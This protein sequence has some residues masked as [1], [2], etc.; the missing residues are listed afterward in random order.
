MDELENDCKY[1]HQHSSTDSNGSNGFIKEEGRIPVKDEPELDQKPD[2]LH[3]TNGLRNGNG[4][5]DAIGSRK[6]ASS[7]SFSTKRARLEDVIAGGN[8]EH[9]VNALET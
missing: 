8:A 3:L 6:R 2:Q 5:H 7:P 4:V 9:P 1:D